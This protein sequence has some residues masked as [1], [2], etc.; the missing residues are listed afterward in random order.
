M[1]F[2]REVG[3]R[4]VS[5]IDKQPWKLKMGRVGKVLSNCEDTDL[6]VTSCDLGLGFGIFPSLKVTHLIPP[7]RLSEDYLVGIARGTIASNLVMRCMRYGQKIEP[8][9]L[10][11]RWAKQIHGLFTQTRRARRFDQAKIQAHKDALAVVHELQIGNVD[12]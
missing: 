10:L 5:D 11:Y 12:R 1:C 6:L 8:P 9:G 7:S 2:R 3:L 4:W